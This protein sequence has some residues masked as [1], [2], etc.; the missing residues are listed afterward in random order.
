MFLWLSPAALTATHVYVPVSLSWALGSAS[1]RPPDRTCNRST[2]PSGTSQCQTQMGELL[3][4]LSK[5]N[6]CFATASH[7]LSA[8]QCSLPIQTR[9]AELQLHASPQGIPGTVKTLQDL[10][11]PPSH[12][13]QT[14]CHTFNLCPELV[15]QNTNSPSSLSDYKINIQKPTAASHFISEISPYIRGWF[16]FL[17]Y[18][19]M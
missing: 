5:R 11:T 1:T 8:L 12:Q 9:K 6:T 18:C 2:A 3:G 14:C 15:P 17:N 13:L 19:C 7:H 4:L 16:S 10:E